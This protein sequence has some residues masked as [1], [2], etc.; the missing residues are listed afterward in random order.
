MQ[1][2]RQ[3]KIFL[4]EDFAATNAITIEGK[5]F[6][7][8]KDSYNAMHGDDTKSNE[9]TLFEKKNSSDVD[10]YMSI[11]TFTDEDLLLGSKLHNR[12]LFVVGYVC[13]QKLNRI[14]ID[15]GSAVNILP[16]RILKELGN[17]IDELSNN[18][19]MIQ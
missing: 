14:L 18:R 17:P 3:V 7:D 5:H 11:I 19:L 1:L 16:L 15:G 12:P 8:S 9:D 2:A 6:D 13:E 10:D 4:E